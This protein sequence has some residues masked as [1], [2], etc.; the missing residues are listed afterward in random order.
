[1]TQQVKVA[2]G[3]ELVIAG[4]VS[5]EI[6]FVPHLTA[7]QI[8]L[9]NADWS[10]QRQMVSIDQLDAQIEL[11]PLLFEQIRIR[12]I[13]LSGGNVILERNEKGVGNWTFAGSASSNGSASPLPQVGRVKLEN[14]K[15]RYRDPTHGLDQT[16]Q[17]DNFSAETAQSTGAVTWSL[18][19]AA[20][21][22]PINLQGTI[23]SDNQMVT[24]PFPIDVQGS[25]GDVTLQSH[26]AIA[27]LS[28]LHGLDVD[29]Q[30][31]GSDLAKINP[32][33][34]GS[35]PQTAAF[36]VA[37]HLSDPDNG[38]RL[39]HTTIN[40][41]KSNLTG[42]VTILLAGDQ[43]M[44]TAQLAGDRVDLA[45]FG[46]APS[47]EKSAPAPSS[48]RLFSTTPWNFD[49]LRSV[50]ADITASVG[51]LLRGQSILKDGKLALTLRRGVLTLQSLTASIDQ[52]QVNASGSLQAAND[53]PALDLQVKGTNIASAPLLTAAGLSDVLTA[54][55]LNL[56]IAVNG[57]A[58]SEHDLMAGLSGNLH[59]NMGAG[60]L[61]NSF[62]Q[63]LLA[64][65]TKLIAFGGT[66]DATRINCLAGHFDIDKG[67][68]ATN[69]LVMD[70]PGAA[71]LGTGNINLGAE[72]LHMRVDSKSKQVSLAA[73]AVPM[74]ISGSLQHPDVAPDAIG[75]LANTG[76]FVAD[77]ANTVTF[78]T[79]ASL[80]G[81]GNGSG[82]VN[83]CATA[84][85]ASAKQ[86]SAGGKIKQGAATVGNGAKQVIQGVGQGAGSAA[87]DVGN[88]LKSGLK[89]I[90][91][92]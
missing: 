37:T 3:R 38:Y 22:N 17:V 85:D 19:G 36:K 64:D 16:L 92:N 20:S 82:S 81:L 34:G 80:T 48:N 55:A 40:F 18:A 78:G 35:L 1:V 41:G 83:A 4:N 87:K 30:V 74:L 54:G 9:Q 28:T 86:T 61:R 49:A 59:F 84:A 15:L 44:V 45:D 27:S 58:S 68:A 66:A 70:T 6:G 62:A 53:K 52:G 88:G 43:P 51:E 33:F 50:D 91:G 23:G 69:S 57:P 12:Q 10:D 75:A 42:D 76:D 8:T 73:L 2:L 71:I 65:L 29:L 47:D 67:V 60:G 72:T 21:Q 14:V 31:S 46:F 32:L 79:L 26:A 11:L 13:T 89:S 25:V 56:D 63:F 77:T 39:D 7:K 90:F 24:G 5:V